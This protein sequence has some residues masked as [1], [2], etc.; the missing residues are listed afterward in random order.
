MPVQ[1]SIN[2]KITGENRSAMA[3]PI[4]L[5]LFATLSV[6]IFSIWVMTNQ[7]RGAGKN[8]IVNAKAALMADAIH[9]FLT[10]QAYSSP[11]NDRFFKE[12]QKFPVAGAMAG[13]WA[14]KLQQ[15]VTGLCESDP[16][17]AKN[18]DYRGEI[19]STVQDNQ[20]IIII[21]VIIENRS[22]GDLICRHKYYE[23]YKRDLVDTIG[24]GV[25]LFVDESESE[26]AASEDLPPELLAK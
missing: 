1:S 9:V 6:G 20:K 22:T 4:V 14:D 2:L 26:G 19:S 3:L 17:L 24:E 21:S 5:A 13:T 12:K 18:L 11:W 25:A 16:W 7:E 15:S 10:A 8:F 23:V